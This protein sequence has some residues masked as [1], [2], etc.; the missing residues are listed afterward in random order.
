MLKADIKE[1]YP[2]I[3]ERLIRKA[4]AFVTNIGVNVTKD[5]I[6]HILKAKIQIASALGT[7]WVKKNSD[8]DNS[9]GARDSCE[10]CELVGLFL[11][12]EVTERLEQL[13]MYFSIALYRD[14]LIIAVRKHGK[15]INSIK[16]EVT[17]IFKKHDLE[18]CDWEEGV[19]L[20]YL[21]INF[22][23]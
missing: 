1:F 12:S 6:E 7:D 10:L 23:L 15:T 2:N 20:N 22:N 19:Q 21:D 5:E 16:S 3:T 8:F 13:G 11:L 9:M 14:D 17:K 4:L 18:F